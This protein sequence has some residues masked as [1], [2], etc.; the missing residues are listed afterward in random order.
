MLTCNLCDRPFNLTLRSPILLSCCGDSTCKEC[1]SNAFNKKA[2][3]M[4]YCPYK[5]KLPDK[6]N[7][8]KPKINIALKRLVESNL[9]VDITCDKHPRISVTGFSKEENRLV[10]PK[11][12]PIG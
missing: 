4:Y 7:P 11:C 8:T 9:P 6:E 10:C 5:C 3:M 12:P 1:W 2:G